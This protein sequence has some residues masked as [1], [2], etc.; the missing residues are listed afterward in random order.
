MGAGGGARFT[1][2]WRGK[3]RS[4]SRQDERYRALAEKYL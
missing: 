1:Q 3:F 4:A 2:R